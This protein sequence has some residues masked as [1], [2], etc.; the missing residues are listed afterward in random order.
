MI[1]KDRVYTKSLMVWY[2]VVVVVVV[3]DIS[4]Q[5]FRPVSDLEL[6]LP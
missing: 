5:L 3:V 6:T 4:L 2:K 1:C